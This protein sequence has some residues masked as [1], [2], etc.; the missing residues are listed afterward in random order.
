MSQ[1]W[2]KRFAR[3]PNQ[4]SSAPGGAPALQHWYRVTVF[5][6]ETWPSLRRHKTY[7][8][9]VISFIYDLVF[10]FFYF[11]FLYFIQLLCEGPMKNVSRKV[12]SPP[13]LPP[14]NSYQLQMTRKLV[15]LL[16]HLHIYNINQPNARLF[17]VKISKNFIINL[18]LH[19]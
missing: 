16:T 17:Q 12:S 19:E 3:G 2:V 14:T 6:M 8:Y 9:L 7:F 18:F 11:R 15:Y 13:L 4:T 10:L 1:N 5:I